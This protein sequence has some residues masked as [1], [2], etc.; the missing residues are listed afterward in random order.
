M[1]KQPHWQTDLDLKSARRGTI[2]NRPRAGSYTQYAVPVKSIFVLQLPNPRFQ[3][4][5]AVPVAVPVTAHVVDPTAILRDV[6][7]L[8]S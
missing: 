5:I 2:R 7:V 8:P 1:R 6:L 3:L 4:A